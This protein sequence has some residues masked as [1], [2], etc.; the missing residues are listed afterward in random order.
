MT[1][2]PGAAST[3]LRS[4]LSG[5]VRPGSVLGVH[6][7]CVYLAVDGVVVALESSDGVGL[8]GSVRLG[9]PSGTAGLADVRPGAPARVGA[10]RLV[11]GDLTVTVARWWQPRRPRP[12]VDGAQVA[13]LEHALAGHP[14]PVP[15]DAAPAELVG[16]GDG[17]TPA[18]DDVLAGMLVGLHHRPE[19][20]RPLAEEVLPLIARTTMLSADLLRHASEGYGIP[21]LIRL[22]DV[23][24]GAAGA[25]GDAEGT[26]VDT[27]L[28]P[29]LERLLRVGHSSGRAL[30]WGLLRG[31]RLALAPGP[32]AI[33][34]GHGSA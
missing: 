16:R 15:V 8:P 11:V 34:S 21:A 14:S 27:A 5:P 4:L 13:A 28:A 29:A 25:E 24:A 32:P 30:A 26:G 33:M 31:A 9:A 7:T 17:L 18:G 6:P 12:G 22:A 3:L 1:L 19:L 10:G 2:S 23:V 20:A